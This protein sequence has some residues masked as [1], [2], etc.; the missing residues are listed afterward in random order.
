MTC[1]SEPREQEV[2]KYVRA[3]KRSDYRLGQRRAQHITE[4]LDRLPR[5]SFLDVSTG[6]GEVLAMAVQR[7]HSPVQGT[8]AVPY[9]CDGDR[10]IQALAHSLP[11]KDSAFDTVTMFD[12]MEH[13]LPEDTAAVCKELARVARHRVLL[14]VHNGPHRVDGMDLHINRRASYED[15]AVE[16]QAAFAPWTL[17]SHGLGQSI[18]AMFEAV[19][20]V[21]EP[22][23]I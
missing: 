4:H 5:G 1:L 12:V 17:I 22:R 19:A 11:F 13:L 10:V 8:E 15:W 20:P 2:A 7:G 18:S 16:L 3:Y 23:A 6:R 9:L 21:A 14:T